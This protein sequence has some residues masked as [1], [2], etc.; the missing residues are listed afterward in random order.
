MQSLLGTNG[1]RPL[2]HK[3]KSY[4]WLE[5]INQLIN[6]V[7]IG[8][9][10]NPNLRKNKAFKQQVKGCLKNAFGPSTNIHIGKILSKPNTRVLALVIFDENRK[11]TYKE[12]VQSVELCNIYHYRKICLY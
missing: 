9:T 11:K 6:E 5:A 12:N 10:M 2:L 3:S 4:I 7:S 8:Y 1:S